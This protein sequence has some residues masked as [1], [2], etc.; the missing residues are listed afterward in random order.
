MLL[1]AYACYIGSQHR[2]RTVCHLMDHCSKLLPSI[3]SACLFGIK[4]CFYSSIFGA[5]Y[6][7]WKF[8][9]GTIDLVEDMV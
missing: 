2:E 1:N 8:K 9:F 6:F 3:E 4:S 5:E 7:L